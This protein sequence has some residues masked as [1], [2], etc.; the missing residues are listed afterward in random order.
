M[1]VGR[2]R[3]F[4]LAELLVGLVLLGIVG[5]VVVRTILSVSRTLRGQQEQAVVE[6]AFDLASDYLAAELG[7]L[8]RGDL[9]QA[10]REAV[11]Y[12]A[13][14]LTGLACLVTATEVRVPE[15]RLW[16]VR[17][18]QP[19]RDSLLLYT[20]ADS[21][22]SAGRGWLSLPL[23]GMGRS[24]CG[25]MPALSLTTTLDPVVAALASLSWQVPVRT[26]E[27]MEAR[28][29]ASLGATWLGA[30]SASAGEAIQPLA[31]PFEQVGSG[32]EFLDSVDAVAVVPSDIRVVRLSLTGRVAGWDGSIAARTRSARATLAPENLW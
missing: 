31:G 8:S 30:R 11:T 13:M 1:P 20:G 3:G 12:R 21:H 32:F 22:S 26:F 10:S 25:T 7:G 4:A 18:P 5:A 2:R 29:Y 17:A 27:V 14:R 19:G 28:L 24:T 16:A 6:S 9:V 23:A 15:E